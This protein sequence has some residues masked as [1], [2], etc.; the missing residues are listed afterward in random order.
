M[1]LNG[2]AKEY[3]F[4]A[5]DTDNSGVKFRGRGVRIR[6][7]WG[8]GEEMGTSITVSTVKMFIFST[9][10]TWE[11]HTCQFYENAIRFM[12][13]FQNNFI[14]KHNYDR[15]WVFSSCLFQTSGSDWPVLGLLLNNWL[16]LCYLIYQECKLKWQ[17]W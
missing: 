6:W 16:T 8:K 9:F 1:E 13:N 2:S 10:H 11:S 15:K 3:L 7:R 17:L 5:M 4:T 12:S 14:S